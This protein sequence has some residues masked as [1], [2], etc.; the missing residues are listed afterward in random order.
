MSDPVIYDQ[1]TDS[2]YI[3]LREGHVV[4]TIAHDDRDFAVD[5]GEDGEPVGYNIQFASKHPDVIAEALQI[6]QR[7]KKM[8][9]E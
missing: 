1:S 4:D 3:T 5:I 8:A 9:A 6:L 7:G 2:M